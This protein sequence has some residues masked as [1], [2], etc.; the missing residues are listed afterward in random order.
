M[1]SVKN[2]SDEHPNIMRKIIIITYISNIFIELGLSIWGE[3]NYLIIAIIVM[4]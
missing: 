2:G 4:N 1:C 3:L